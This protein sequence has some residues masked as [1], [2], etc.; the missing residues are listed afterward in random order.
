MIF[1]KYV[2]CT[3][4]HLYKKPHGRDAPN[5]NW[6]D[7]DCS[8]YNNFPKPGCLWPGESK[9]DFGYPICHNAIED[10]K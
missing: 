5:N 7:E 4:C 10:L 1:G 6:C 3:V 8:G 9:E 2:E